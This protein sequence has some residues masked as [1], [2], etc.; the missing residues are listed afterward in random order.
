[1]S[2]MSTNNSK[3][4]YLTILIYPLWAL[5]LSFKYFKS[6][7]AKNLFWFF[8]IFLG[9]IHICFPEGG[10]GSDGTRYAQRLIE[11]HQEPVSWE[12]FSSS[13]YETGEFADVYQPSTTYLLS[14]ITA[15]PRWLF[16]IYAMVFGFFYSRNVWFV[17]EK[18]HIIIGFPL[19]FMTLY[20]ILICPV[21]DIN[22]V[23]MWTALHVFVYGALH[24]LYNAEKSKLIWCFAS[25]LF[26][27]SFF[28]PLSILLIYH[29][30][31][32]SLKYLLI[33][34]ILSFFINELD[35][36]KIGDTLSSFMP[37]FLLRRVT[38]YTNEEYAQALIAAKSNLNFY[39]EG[40]R[41]FVRWA[42]AILLFVSCVWGEKIIKTNKSLFNLFCFSLFMYAISNILSSIPSVGRFTVLS[43]MFAFASVI[44]FYI[45]CEKNN[46]KQKVISAVFKLTPI[47]LIL[48]IIVSF[49]TGTDYYGISIIFN[50]IAAL[51]IE[52]KQPVIQF[53]KSIF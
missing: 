26:H 3:V 5:Y 2:I 17:L 8:C 18:F 41:T 7:H 9:M 28:L 6:P 43:Q 47:L 36:G 32:K 13:F 33:F 11:L 37:S 29:F 48:P 52:D 45:F 16:M 19:I 12:S 46:Y 44:I 25:L 31:P 42:I 21:W 20:Y 30:I 14:I 38:G 10:S 53:I 50:P 22:G 27:F 49:R 24:Y 23:R 35:L 1:M 15:N 4:V 39:V 40:S 34:F 51:F